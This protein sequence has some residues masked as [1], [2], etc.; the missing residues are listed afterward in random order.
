MEGH[1]GRLPRYGGPDFG[2]SLV[3][4]LCRVMDLALSCYNAL[5]GDMIKG[6]LRYD[7]YPTW[8][9]FDACTSYSVVEVTAAN[10]AAYH[11]PADVAGLVVRYDGAALAKVD[12]LEI[13]TE[14]IEVA[15]G[16]RVVLVPDEDR[17]GRMWWAEPATGC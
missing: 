1:F 12:S 14:L 16:C 4:V 3:E 10:A 6:N 11:L 9:D 2:R 8:V 15:S 7:T 13:A 5:V 17:C